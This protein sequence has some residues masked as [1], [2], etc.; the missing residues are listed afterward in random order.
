MPSVRRTFVVS[1][2]VQGVFYREGAKSEAMRLGLTGWA[3]NRNDGKVE[4]V[5]EG[6]PTNIELMARWL[7]Q[8]PPRAAVTDV[9]SSGFGAPEG[10][11]GFT[12]R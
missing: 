4:V 6:E 11:A 3:T 10:I 5:V 2:R 12:V 7:K 1:G 9:E 8:G